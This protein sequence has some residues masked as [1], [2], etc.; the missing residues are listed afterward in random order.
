[1]VVGMVKWRCHHMGHQ[2]PNL[3]EGAAKRQNELGVIGSKS[4]AGRILSAE[5]LCG[6]TSIANVRALSMMAWRQ[7]HGNVWIAMNL[8]PAVRFD[9]LSSR[10]CSQHTGQREDVLQAVE[11]QGGVPPW[12]PLQ[13]TSAPEAALTTATAPCSCG[14]IPPASYSL[15][16]VV[17]QAVVCSVSVGSP[18][19]F[20]P[21]GNLT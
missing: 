15:V 5:R 6:F 7:V 13:A 17:M 3:D 1:M 12:Q 2:L 11:E 9:A 8:P 14:C 18:L 16:Q 19:P 4:V 21:L 10:L 20:I